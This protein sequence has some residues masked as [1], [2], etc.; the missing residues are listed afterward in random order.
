[1]VG[2]VAVPVL[3]LAAPEAVAAWKLGKTMADAFLYQRLGL[4]TYEIGQFFRV[5]GPALGPAAGVA[6]R[7]AKANYQKCGNPLFCP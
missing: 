6:W 7:Q 5:Y 4:G 3:V 2:A 1:M